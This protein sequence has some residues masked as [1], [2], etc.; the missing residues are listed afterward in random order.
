MHT[1]IFPNTNNELLRVC[2]HDIIYIEADS[3]YCQM[4]LKGDV[5]QALWFNMKHFTSIIEEQMQDEMPIF[6]GVGRSLIIN[7]LYI[8]RINPG[9]GELLLYGNGC[10]SPV[11]L[12]AS[13]AA[14]TQLKN[15]MFEQKF[16]AL[17]P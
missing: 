5:T 8:Y 16:D 1:L 14:L 12:H 11:S 17:N 4:H 2:A 13:V 7:R 9:K 10:S 15:Y 6:I 3:N